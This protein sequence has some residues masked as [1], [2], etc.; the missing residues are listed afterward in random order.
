MTQIKSQEPPPSNDVPQYKFFNISI[1]S[2]LVFEGLE[3][4]F[5]K[6]SGNFE[7]IIIETQ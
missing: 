4:D 3:D 6:M 7:E 2:L 1:C 5:G